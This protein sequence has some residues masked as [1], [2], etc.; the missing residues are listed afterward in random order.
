MASLAE[1]LRSTVHRGRGIAGT[2]G[3]RPHRVYILDEQGDPETGAAQG[4]AERLEITEGSGQPPRITMKKGEDIA[5]G[6][7][8][9]NIVEIGPITPRDGRLKEILFPETAPLEG[10][11]ITLLIVGPNWPTGERFRVLNVDGDKALRWV[12]TAQ[13]EDEALKGF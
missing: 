9:Q 7:S 8:P 10:Q 6:N 3:F 11:F 12:I 2:L 5:F 1:K 4:F 13:L